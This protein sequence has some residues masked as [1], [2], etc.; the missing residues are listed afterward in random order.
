MKTYLI[1]LSILSLS[2]LVLSAEVIETWDFEQ[3]DGTPLG[4]IVSD[5]GRY[6]M[7][8]KKYRFKENINLKTPKNDI[9]SK[10]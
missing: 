2:L 10:K 3:A 9:Y 5:Q 7:D 4:G 8:L 1:I 6:F